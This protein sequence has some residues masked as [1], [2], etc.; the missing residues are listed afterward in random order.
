MSETLDD[1]GGY[2][3]WKVRHSTI[4]QA[5]MR[6]LDGGT[7]RNL[8]GHTITAGV[9]AS[10]SVL[11]TAPNLATF[12]VTVGNQTNPETRGRFTI[13]INNLTLPPGNY[14]WYCQITDTHD[15]AYL[16]GP[17]IVKPWVV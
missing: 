3:P 7:A 2:I 1:T 16:H 10:E 5:D 13:T 9:K 11:H 15:H 4:V 14:H 17:F 8:T 6:V 12:T